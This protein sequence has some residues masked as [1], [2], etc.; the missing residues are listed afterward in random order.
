MS[1]YSFAMGILWFSVF[2]LLGLLIRK[3]KFPVKFSVAPSLLL[4]ILTLFRMMFALSFPGQIII[5]SEVIYPPV[6]DFARF[7]L[8][9]VFWI[10][11]NPLIA[12]VGLWFAVSAVLMFRFV[13]L[14]NN[15]RRRTDSLTLLPRDTYAESL[16]DSL[17]GYHK[18]RR[19][20][21]T[22]LLQNTP[23]TLGT[24]PYIIMPDVDFPPKEL[25]IILLHEWKHFLDR[26]V[27]TTLIVEVICI[28]FWWN[29]LV[30][31]LKDNLSF[32]LE[33]KCDYHAISGNEEF[34]H[35]INSLRRLSD[36]RH[37]DSMRKGSNDS[38][39]LKNHNQM[40]SYMM[41]FVDPELVSSVYVDL[42]LEKIGFKSGS[43]D[44][45][46]SGNRDGLKK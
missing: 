4:L 46:K 7:E 8:I 3:L 25:Q 16:L 10:S 1:P 43:K 39:K 6:V 37:K 2:V 15:D 38:K 41:S 9:R 26:D 42:A 5:L 34:E 14:C 45:L 36:S 28:I 13:R 35:Y 11:V 20:F 19:V 24:K 17:V 18:K 32:A 40:N 33:L 21:R 44:G 29:P 12:F 23:F 27:Q 31:I 30:Y 22:N